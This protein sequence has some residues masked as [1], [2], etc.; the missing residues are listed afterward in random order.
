ML[1]SWMERGFP[2]RNLLIDPLPRRERVRWLVEALCGEEFCAGPIWAVEVEDC[3]AEGS[4]LAGECCDVVTEALVIAGELDDLGLD[5]LRA[6]P[7]LLAVP[8]RSEAVDLAHLGELLGRELGCLGARPSLLV[9][10]LVL[11]VSR[12]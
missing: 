2:L 12:R 6:L 11:V 7:A 8:L 3:L 4:D 10:P 1:D 9:R 5:N